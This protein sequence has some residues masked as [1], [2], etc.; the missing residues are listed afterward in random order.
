MLDIIAPHN[1]KL[2]MTIKIIGVN[3]AKT[4]LAGARPAAQARAKQR[5][6]QQHN[7]Q[8]DNQRCGGADK[9]EKNRVIAR[10]IAEEL[11]I[12]H[13]LPLRLLSNSDKC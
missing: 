2:A 11:H 8:D 4:R 10:E 1:D 5:P 12:S 7:D 9:P 6:H 3:D 13:S